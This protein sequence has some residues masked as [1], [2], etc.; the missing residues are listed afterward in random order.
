MQIGSAILSAAYRIVQQTECK[1]EEVGLMKQYKILPLLFMI[2]LF[3]LVLC[4]CQTDLEKQASSDVVSG[5]AVSGQAVESSKNEIVNTSELEL[6]VLTT[7]YYLNGIDDKW[8]EAVNSRLAECGCDFRVTFIGL[9]DEEYEE[10]QSGID[11]RKRNG[12]QAD[13]IF[14]GWGDEVPTGGFKE[15]FEGSYDRNIQ[16]G[17]LLKLDKYLKSEAGKELKECYTEVEWDCVDKHGGIYGVNNFKQKNLNTY[18]MIN[19]NIVKDEPDILTK[20]K[21]DW[22]KVRR[23]VEEHREEALTGLHF[24]WDTEGIIEDCERQFGK[25]GYERA[26]KGFYACDGKFINIWDDEWVR[27]FWSNV[28]ALSKEGLVSVDSQLGR[29]ARDDGDFVA[30][31]G[32]YYEENLSEHI[33]YSDSVGKIPVFRY[34]VAVPRARKVQNMVTGVASWTEHREQALQLLKL[35]NCD[36]KL[37]NLMSFGIEGRDYHLS[38]GYVDD[39]N[40]IG[41][42]CM[43]NT[44]ITYPSRAEQKDKTEMLRRV[45]ERFQVSEFEGFTLDTKKI[46]N[47]KKIVDVVDGAYLKF[48]TEDEKETEESFDELDKELKSLDIDTA[49][50]QWNRQY[51]KWKAAR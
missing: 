20:G 33:F 43:A 36:E 13:L 6:V 41:A 38:D 37:A 15:S 16:A 44:Q 51:K 46:K 23:I 2:M 42:L 8:R 4:A 11:A 24:D 28:H 32:E 40:G 1:R 47:Y 3:V 7:D 18:L 48:L 34:E 19:A 45:N 26:A 25:M 10:Y 29:Q 9:N 30:A 5:Q 27:S 22:G 39:S 21:L 14:T 35:L 31:V 17:N 50:A 12:E 49:V